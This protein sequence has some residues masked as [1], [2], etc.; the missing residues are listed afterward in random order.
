VRIAP[1]P[2]LVH[3]Y[4]TSVV[5]DLVRAAKRDSAS[6]VLGVLAPPE[7]VRDTLQITLCLFV[8]G[9]LQTKTRCTFNLGMD[10]TFETSCKSAAATTIH[11]L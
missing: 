8:F 11:T 4:L 7:Q 3:A 10:S 9:A 1:R 5:W 2:V 6:F